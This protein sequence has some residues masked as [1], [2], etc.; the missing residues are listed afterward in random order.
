M[1]CYEKRETETDA[2]ELRRRL[3]AVTAAESHDEPEVHEI[4]RTGPSGDIDVVR[5]LQLVSENDV[6]DGSD[7]TSH[8]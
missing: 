6:L 7:L 4:P 5:L 3:L 1:H 8:S 2:E